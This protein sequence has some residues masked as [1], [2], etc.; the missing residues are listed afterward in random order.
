VVGYTTTLL[1]KKQEGE[2]LE[3]FVGPLGKPVHFSAKKRVIG[4]GR[5]RGRRPPLSQLRELARRG[6]R[7]M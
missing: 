5:R 4:I 7:S 6:V 2:K 3:D 1:S